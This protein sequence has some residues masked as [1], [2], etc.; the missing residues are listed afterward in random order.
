MARGGDSVLIRDDE[1]HGM[2]WLTKK[3]ELIHHIDLAIRESPDWTL[4][5]TTAGEQKA[6]EW[7]WTSV[8]FPYCARP[9]MQ[10]AHTT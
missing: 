10:K 3:T 6:K 5:N 8:S 1:N 9:S 2:M 7:A 4:C